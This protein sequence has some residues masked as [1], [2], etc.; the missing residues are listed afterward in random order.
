[1]MIK[2]MV[3]ILSREHFLLLLNKS[4]KMLVMMVLL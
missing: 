3:L 4:L 2:D 1:M